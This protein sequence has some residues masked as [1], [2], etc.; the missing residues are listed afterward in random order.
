MFRATSRY[1]GK[2][3]CFGTDANID[4]AR[5]CKGECEFSSGDSVFERYT[6]RV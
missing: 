2:L 1:L 4:V 5:V 3:E 6:V